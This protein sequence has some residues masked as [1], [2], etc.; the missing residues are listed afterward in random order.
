MLTL[1]IRSV[2]PLAGCIGIFGVAGFVTSEPPTDA[3]A[4][5]QKELG[6]GAVTLPFE[7]KCG[8]LKAILKQLDVPESSQVLVFAK[9]SLQ[10]RFISP[11]KPRAIYFND[12]TYVGWVNGGELIEIASVDPERGTRFYTIRNSPQGAPK[13]DQE[14][15]RC[16]QCHTGPG[17][18]GA[19]ALVAK[20]VFADRN[21][22]LLNSA[23]AHKVDSTTPI[24]DRWGGWYVTGSHGKQRHMGNSFASGSYADPV[25]DTEAG[26]NLSNLDKFVNSGEYLNGYSDIVAL[27]VLEHQMRVQNLITKT[28]VSV[29]REEPIE[30]AC[31]PLVEAILC[32]GEPKLI[33]PI[34]GSNNFQQE[35]ESGGVR[36]NAGQSLRALDL[37]NRLFRYSFS[38]MVYSASFAAMPKAAKDRIGSRLLQI[39]S[40]KDNSPK[41]QHVSP[42]DRK[43]IMAILTE[44]MPGFLPANAQ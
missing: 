7:P 1:W 10:S 26:A 2:L 37:Q 34:K 31:E 43:T 40:G 6:A 29:R 12:H 13:F 8:Y 4:N 38:P 28:G 25:L 9:T 19:P 11:Q 39:L 32:V 3:I 15:S 16:V 23:G 35:Y 22:D 5:L 17:L 30:E 18:G 21:G 27:M 44:T 24:E 14:S 42:S 41:F 33:S 20:S 36:D